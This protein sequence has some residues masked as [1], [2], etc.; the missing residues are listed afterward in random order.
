MNSM[1]SMNSMEMKCTE[2]IQNPAAWTP[3]VT[4]LCIALIVGNGNEQ[5]MQVCPVALTVP[6]SPSCSISGAPS[7]GRA[8]AEQAHG[9]F[10]VGAVE[11]DTE[12]TSLGARASTK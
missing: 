7:K 12:L 9:R 4:V 1:N 2:S 8:N 11:R 3:G 6:H 5:G 10:A